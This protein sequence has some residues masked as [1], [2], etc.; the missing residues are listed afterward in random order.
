MLLGARMARTRRGHSAPRLRRA[1]IAL[2]ASGAAALA[3]ALAGPAQAKTVWLCK[4]GQ[5]PNPC[6][7]SLQTTVITSDGAATIVNTK[8]AKRPKVDCFYVYPTVSD[9][10]TTNADLTVDPQQT[11]IA[12]FQASRFSQRCRVFAPM[13][14]Q[15]T[16][17]GIAQ[18]SIP[19]EAAQLAY[20]DV[21]AAWREYMR[22]YNNGRGVVL[23]GHSQGTGMLTQLVREKI[24]PFPAIREQLVAAL[25]IG[26]NVTVKRGSDKGGAFKKVPACHTKRELHCVVAYS[27]F[28]QTPPDNTLFGRANGRFEQS[29]GLPVRTDVEVLCNNPAALGGGLAPLATLAPTS[30]FPGTL[31]LGIQLLFNGTP[32]TAPT[33]WI[34]PQDH[35]LGHCVQGN[36]ANVLMISPVGSARTLTPIPDASWGLHLA[37][38]NIA[39]GNLVDLVRS[40][41]RAYLKARAKQRR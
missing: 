40:Q 36:G 8:R 13:Y 28:N 37:D 3:L 12:R 17:A 10:T 2:A 4:P 24:D 6:F 32:P 30:P 20:G 27:V 11:A 14:R 15:L 26:G 34:Q 25:L 31:G 1:L 41:S 23:I 21:R 7:E 29:L 16:L 35:Y 33:P 38:V 18:P 9:Q 5:S 19:A 22:R 39:L